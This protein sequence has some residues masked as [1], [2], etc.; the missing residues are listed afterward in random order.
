MNQKLLSLKPNVYYDISQHHERESIISAIKY[1]QS[2]NEPF[3]FNDDE[4]KF[5]RLSTDPFDLKE[6]Q[7]YSVVKR[8]RHEELMYNGKLISIR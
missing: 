2:H 7:G 6:E 5:Q 4:T 8:G 3:M 1:L